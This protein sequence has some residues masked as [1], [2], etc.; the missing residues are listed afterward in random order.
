M[1]GDPIAQATAAARTLADHRNAE[2]SIGIVAFNH[3][4]ITV[5]APTTKQAK[6]DAALANPPELARGTR[7]YDAVGAGLD[8]LRQSGISGGS[9]VVLSDG[10]DTGSRSNVDEVASA[11]RAAGVRVYTVGLRSS[12]FDPGPLQQLAD[13]G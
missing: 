2:Q 8:M 12:A 1:T 7:I 13:T 4:A 6:I 10:S 3:G 11:A 5:L 9:L